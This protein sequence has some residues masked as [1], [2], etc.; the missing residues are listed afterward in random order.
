[1]GAA[2]I[3]KSLFGGRTARIAQE[4]LPQLHAFV[5]VSVGGRPMRSVSV[6]DVRPKEIVM[7][8][9][10]GRAGESAT[11]VYTNPVGKYRFA[12]KIAS[13][14]DGSTHF[15]MPARVDTVGGGAQKRS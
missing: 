9:V 10:L 4:K 15:E 1:M 8:S 2:V 6:E 11:F 12:T 5:D 14:A 3:F 7:S 13:V